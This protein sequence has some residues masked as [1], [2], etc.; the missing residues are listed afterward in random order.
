MTS[1]PSNATLNIAYTKKPFVSLN[2]VEIKQ[3]H[4]HCFGVAYFKYCTKMDMICAH[5]QRRMSSHA[6]INVIPLS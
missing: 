5:H 6:S 4:N 1:Y 2:Y 3:A